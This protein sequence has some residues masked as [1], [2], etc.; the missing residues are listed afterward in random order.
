MGFEKLQHLMTNCRNMSLQGV[1]TEKA[2]KTDC[3]VKDVKRREC[4]QKRQWSV[5]SR[6]L[7]EVGWGILR[8]LTLSPVKVVS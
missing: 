8:C 5:M 6:E 3:E 7:M 4:L 1:A 2:V